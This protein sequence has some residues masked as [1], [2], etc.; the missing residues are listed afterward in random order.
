MTP[1]P[2]NQ[3]SPTPARPWLGRRQVLAGGMGLLALPLAGCGWSPSSGGPPFEFHEVDDGPVFGPGL[4]DELDLEFYAAVVTDEAATEA[5]DVDRLPPDAHSFI[6]ATDFGSQY[7][8]VV[9]VSGVNSSMAFDVAD[10][11]EG[12]ANTTVVASL[13]DRTPHSEDR[14]I[15]T[16]LV[17]VTA[18]GGFDPEGVTVEFHLNDRH[19]TFEGDRVAPSG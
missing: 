10:V 4:Q 18:Q 15:S 2:S 19:E 11:A 12:G 8:A 16:L 3:E 13:D 1:T 7:L 5:F 17:R 6:R 9:Q 14:V